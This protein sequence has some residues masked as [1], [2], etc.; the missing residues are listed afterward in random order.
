MKEGFCFQCRDGEIEIGN[1]CKDCGSLLRDIS[2]WD[3]SCECGHEVYP[4][5]HYCTECG[6]RITEDRILLYLEVK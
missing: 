1:Y 3:M 5:S 6:E 4:W 2:D